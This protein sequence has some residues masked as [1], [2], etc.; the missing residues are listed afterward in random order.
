MLLGECKQ[1]VHASTRHVLILL[2]RAH[3]VNIVPLLNDIDI[4]KMGKA[5]PLVRVQLRPDEPVAQRLR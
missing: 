2:R 3:P 4:P 1:F 5:T